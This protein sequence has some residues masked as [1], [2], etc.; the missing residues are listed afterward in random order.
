MSLQ[1]WNF[2]KR[3]YE[4]YSVP[5]DWNISIYCYEY[6]KKYNAYKAKRRAE[7]RQEV[8]V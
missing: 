5:D 7:E 8:T 3:E 2:D 4:P 6:R 1:R